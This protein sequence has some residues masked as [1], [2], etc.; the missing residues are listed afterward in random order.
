MQRIKSSGLLKLFDQFSGVRLHRLL[1]VGGLVGLTSALLIALVNYAARQVTLDN[2]PTALFFVF[3]PLLI[4]YLLLVRLNNKENIT[5]TES[6][7]YRY[8]MQV[9]SLVLK[10]D[11]ATLDKIGHAQIQNALSRNSQMISQGVTMLVPTTQSASMIFFAICYLF[12]ISIPAALVTM[13]FAIVVSTFAVRLMKARQDAMIKSWAQEGL[14]LAHIAEMLAGFKEIKLNSS[15]ALDISADLITITRSAK[16]EKT[17]AIIGLANIYSSVQILMYVLVGVII[18]IVPVIAPNFTEQ[19]VPV[20]TTV[21]FIAGSMTGMIQTMPFLSQA[22]TSARE[23]L[24]FMDKLDIIRKQAVERED[25]PIEQLRSIRLEN[26][27]QHYPRVPPSLP[28]VVGPVSYEFKAGEV[29]F[30]RGGNGSGK[31]SLIRILTGLAAS[32]GGRIFVNDEE[33]VPTESQ[34]Y[35]DLFSAIFGDFHLF[36]KLYGM[37]GSDPDE[38]NHWLE[39]LEIIDKVQYTD[40]RFTTLSLSTGQKKRVALLVSILERRPVIILDEWASDQ[41]PEFRKFFYE[42][43]VPELRAMKK[44]VIAITHDDHY[45]DRADHLL[46][47]DHGKLYENV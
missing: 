9:M 2:I 29:Y 26:I 22:D 4:C 1:Y 41:D 20:S 19:V 27:T 11:I 45:F 17:S 34:S 32:D 16:M 15:R 36:Q 30:V 23:I 44:L 31:T 47:V 21:L 14:G 43:I 8:R 40:G 24:G 37:E 18:F 5:N 38:I 39:K 12:F 6:L 13:F 28:F 35:R 3:I 25:Y 42:T 46:I 7:I 10:A 33:V